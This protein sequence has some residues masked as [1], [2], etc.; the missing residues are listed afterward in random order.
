VLREFDRFARE[1]AS[2]IPGAVKLRESTG[3]AG[4]LLKEVKPSS[5]GA[6]SCR[7]D[8]VAGSHSHKN[9]NSLTGRMVQR[10]QPSFGEVILD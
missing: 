1:Q 5:V 4:G 3:R 9:D 10:A 6:A 7:E 8:I 2:I